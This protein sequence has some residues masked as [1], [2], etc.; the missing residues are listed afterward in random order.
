MN[1][2]QLEDFKGTLDDQIKAEED[3][4][5]KLLESAKKTLDADAKLQELYNERKAKGLSEMQKININALISNRS[6]EL[7]R[8]LQDQDKASKE[9]LKRLKKYKADAEN[10]N[11][12]N[13]T[14][15]SD[16]SDKEIKAA[17]DAAQKAI[18]IA[19]AKELLKL[20]Q[21]Y[22]DKLELEKEYNAR[23]LAAELA[24]LKA[25]E[26]IEPDELKRL[27][28]QSQIILKQKEFAAA[29]KEALPVMTKIS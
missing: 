13:K 12:K 18:D 16:L 6:R 10:V 8:E 14:T 26:K 24:L 4:H 2:R 1:A 29:V 21:Y 20:S 17:Q 5:S 15:T 3:Y 23:V 9:R 11:K 28:L 7:T 19:H 25:K 27:E 22:A